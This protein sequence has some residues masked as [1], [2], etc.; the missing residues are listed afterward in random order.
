MK[1]LKDLRKRCICYKHIKQVDDTENESSNI[2]YWP[3]CEAWQKSICQLLGIRFIRGNVSHTQEHFNYSINHFPACCH[4]KI[5]GDG[6][7]FFRALA[8]L[9]TGSQDD[10]I[11][12]RTLITT[13]IA[14]NAGLMSCYI[15][16]SQSVNDYLQQTNMHSPSVWATEV[17]IFAAANMLGTSIFVFTKCGQNY[18][19][20]KFTN[21]SSADNSSL[22][23]PRRLYKYLQP[24]C[25]VL[26]L[27]F[28][29]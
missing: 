20:L 5:L 22:C 2:P 4:W 27:L 13:Y 1:N 6:N 11:E 24:L 14:H 23:T 21:S 15:G 26:R 17:E 18:K 19:W 3:V 16:H 28:F 8:F 29:H 10:H 25:M 12:F 7:C 9:V